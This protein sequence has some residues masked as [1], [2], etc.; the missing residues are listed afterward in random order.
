MS[1][2]RF[3]IGGSSRGLGWSLQSVDSK[4]LAASLAVLAFLAIYRFY[5]YWTSGF[6]VS[7]EFGYFYDAIHTAVYSDRWF[8]GWTNI[9]LFRVLGISTVD[10][11]SYLLPFYIFFWTGLTL[12]VFYKLLKLLGFNEITTA[13]SLIS[14]LVLISFM[15]LSLGFLTEPVGLCM[16]M[17][18]VYFLA[19]YMKSTTA[20]GS[21]VFPFLSGCF[22]G[23]ASGTRE[24]YNAFL[25]GGIVIIVV[26]ALGRRNE[27]LRTRRFGSRVVLTVA[28][29]AFVLPSLF[30][31]FV[32]T[33]AYTSQV[34]PI[35][36]ELAQSI[37]SN[38]LTSGGGGGG[39]GNSPGLP[40]TTYPFYRQFVLTNTLLIFFG[41]V[42]LGWGPICF[43]IG[44]AGFLILFRR[45]F[46]QKEL[47][48]RFLFLTSLTALG[49][50]LVVSFIYA[51][52]PTY[53]SFQNYSTLIR[54]SDTALPAYFL[55]API[56]MGSF[57]KSRRRVVSFLAVCI[58]FLLIAVPV[59]QVYAASN[60][61]YASGQNP[62]QLG[63]RTDAALLRS[64]FDS[65]GSD[66]QSINLVGVPY[67]WIFTPGVEDLGSVH[68]YSIGPNPLFP[69]L[70]YSSFVSM[71]WTALY[72]Y[73][74][75]VQT[76][77][78]SRTYFAQLLNAT[79]PANQGG[80][81]PYT[82]VAS[83]AVLHGQDFTLYE[84]QLRW[85]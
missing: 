9:I 61:N 5:N 39:G 21:V 35:A 29:V 81:P 85:S 3:R 13:L 52:D 10:A 59:Y 64:Y 30:F 8:F 42:F 50:Y 38:P 79:A 51:P 57:A 34:A 32:P 72:I 67:G 28:V 80:A 84:V 20:K 27:G 1:G 58:A 74:N 41:G 68:A 7:D 54:F 69:E 44:L 82:V 15:L 83:R 77:E 46:R 23:F 65:N 24:P 6:F 73:L 2:R 70:N 62:F 53:F 25:I 36:S 55:M 19:R 17:V 78:F 18:G 12:F 75:D 66:S 45:T 31:L 26:L 14:S 63:Y 16:A 22:F 71:R 11:F 43:A 37:L 4:V 76:S 60:F 33:R 47:T 56:V 49:S 40:S 48:P